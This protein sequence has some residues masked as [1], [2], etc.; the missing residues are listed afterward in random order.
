MSNDLNNT[1]P[2]YQGWEVM[3]DK[4]N[5]V[6]EKVTNFLK[7]IFTEAVEENYSIRQLSHV[8]I[9]AVLML[10]AETLLRRNAKEHESNRPRL[11]F[12]RKEE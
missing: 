9:G 7:P 8:I 11:K 5:N 2:L 10:E 4:A 1:K 6:E 3:S 12:N